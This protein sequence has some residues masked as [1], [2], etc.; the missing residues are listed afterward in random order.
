MPQVD[1]MNFRVEYVRNMLGREAAKRATK[2]REVD[3]SHLK[4]L[5]LRFPP[6]MRSGVT[7]NWCLRLHLE[8]PEL[9]GEGIGSTPTAP[10]DQNNRMCV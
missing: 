3:L 10:I 4:G 7:C 8:V 1:L 6:K 5:H 2:W 9:I